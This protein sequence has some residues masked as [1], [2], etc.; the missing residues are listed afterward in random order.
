MRSKPYVEA[1]QPPIEEP[2]MKRPGRRIVVISRLFFNEMLVSGE[3]HHVVDGLPADAQL[4]KMSM[5]A[6]F[7]RD[8]VACLFESSEWEPI[9]EGDHIPEF[10]VTFIKLYPYRGECTVFLKDQ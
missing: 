7:S 9:P 1:D 10:P 8:A 3:R 6:L 2:P 4:V 5:D